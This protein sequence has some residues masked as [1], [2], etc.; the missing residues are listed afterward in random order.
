L[1]KPADEY[2]AEPSEKQNK[3]NIFTFIVKLFVQMRGQTVYISLAA[4]REAEQC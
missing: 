3:N 2:G 1:E 4:V